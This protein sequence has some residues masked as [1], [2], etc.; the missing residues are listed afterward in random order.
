MITR[1]GQMAFFF[2]SSGGAAPGW[3]TL[4]VSY[5]Q[6]SAQH[7]AE[8]HSTSAPLDLP[9]LAR[10]WCLMGKSPK[11]KHGSSGARPVVICVGYPQA[12]C[13]GAGALHGARRRERALDQQLPAGK[14]T[15]FSQGKNAILRDSATNKRR[16]KGKLKPI[17]VPWRCPL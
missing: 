6:S 15:E 7:P 3:G 5:P 11:A 4:F 8:R 9:S 16:I 14:M 17:K 2:P 10:I 12:L 13:A 1:V